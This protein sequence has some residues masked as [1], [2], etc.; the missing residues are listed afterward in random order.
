ML[1]AKIDLGTNE[2]KEFPIHEKDLIEKHLKGTTL[3][4]TITDFSLVGTSYR[5]V[6]PVLTKDVDLVA[7]YSH[8]VESVSAIYNEETGEFDR[9]YALVEIPEYKREERKKYRLEILR[10]K[11][12]KGFI[13]LDAKFSRHASEVRLGL[14][15]TDAI[16]YLD[17]KAQSFRDVT[18]IENPWAID[19]VTFFEV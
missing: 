7:S 8:S 17:E 19:D 15:P 14:T 11:R 5:C 13:D 10:K 18:D 4:K 1:Y 9:V 3:P 2:V 12:I 16:E 6:K